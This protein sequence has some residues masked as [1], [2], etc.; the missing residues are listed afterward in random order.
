MF[1]FKRIY[2]IILCYCILFLFCFIFGVH[3]CFLMV[4]LC[5]DSCL[6]LSNFLFERI[7]SF[8]NLF[9]KLNCFPLYMVTIHEGWTD[10]ILNNWI[11]A[12]LLTFD[13]GM[14]KCFIWIDIRIF[15]CLSTSSGPILCD[16]LFGVIYYS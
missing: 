14:M 7:I 3:F 2:Y 4:L 10:L 5:I 12:C 13:H 8:G 15:F 6:I 16:D 11:G 1:L 9:S